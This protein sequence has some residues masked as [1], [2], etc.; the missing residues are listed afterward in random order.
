MED[1]EVKEL[2]QILLDNRE[3]YQN[4]ICGWALECKKVFLMSLDEY[5][6]IIDYLVVNLQGVKFEGGDLCWRE[7]DVE[8][9]IIWIKEQIEKL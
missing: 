6:E 8:S 9:R 3:L 2:F 7:F 5:Y 1:R 4:G